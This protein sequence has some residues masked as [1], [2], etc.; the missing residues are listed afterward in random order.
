M[1]TLKIIL[2]SI[3]LIAIAVV[4]LAINILLKKKGKFPET[5]VGHN[6]EMRKRGITCAKCEVEKQCSNVM[7]EEVAQPMTKK[8]T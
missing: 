6:P 8:T 2:L 1:F 3:G 7:I 5:S 4:G